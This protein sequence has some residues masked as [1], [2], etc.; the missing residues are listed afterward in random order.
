MHCRGMV[1]SDEEGEESRRTGREALVLDAVDCNGQTAIHRAAALG[2]A[3]IV[4]ALLGAGA[5]PS[6][7]RSPYSIYVSVTYTR[8]AYPCYIHMVRSR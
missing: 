8:V 5:S 2:Y 4:F 6:V 7:V 1:S 3:D